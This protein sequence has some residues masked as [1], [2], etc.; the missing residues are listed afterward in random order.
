M[1]IK[2]A[3]VKKALDDY[4]LEVEQAMTKRITQYK[5]VKSGSLKNSPRHTVS[6]NGAGGTAKLYFVEY[7][8]F[9]DMGVNKFNPLGGAKAISGALRE[10]SEENKGIKPKKIYSKV[11]YGKLNGLIGDLLYG[12]TEETISM[13]KNTLQYGN[14]S[15]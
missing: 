12:Y 2:Q 1:D 3:F 5:A 15:N 4:M 10:K 11:A 14:S 6:D 13:L 7:G 8:R 9:I